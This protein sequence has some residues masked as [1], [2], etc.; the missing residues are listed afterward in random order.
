M[1]TFLIL[2]TLLSLTLTYTHSLTHTPITVSTLAGGGRLGNT[3]GSTQGIGVEARMSQ[4]YSLASDANFVYVPDYFNHRILRVD[5]I[6]GETSVL[7]GSHEASGDRDGY[8]HMARF[9]SPNAVDL[10]HHGNL[11]V[12][13]YGN[14]RIRKVEIATG[15][16][17]TIAGS[18]AGYTDGHGTVAKFNGPMGLALDKKG[19]VAY[20]TDPSN[21]LIRRL[22]LI[23]GMVSTIAGQYGQ[24]GA[25]DG[26]GNKA[27]F[28]YPFGISCDQSGK[29]LYV[30]DFSAH[31]I[32]T[33]DIT[34]SHVST[35]WGRHGKSGLTEGRGIHSLL[36]GPIDVAVDNAGNAYVADYNNN[37]IRKMVLSTGQTSTYVGHHQ[38]GSIDGDS[39]DA[40]FHGPHG[41]TINVDANDGFSQ[42]MY[43]AD[44]NNN[45]IRKVTMENEGSPRLAGF[46][47][48]QFQ[49]YG[50][51]NS[52]YN[53]IS[54]P[55]FQLNAGFSYIDNVVC[56]RNET[57]CSGPHAG[58]YLSVMGFRVGTHKVQVSLENGLL[59]VDLDDRRFAIRENVIT[60]DDKTS[61]MKLTKSNELIISSNTFRISITSDGSFLSMNAALLASDWLSQGAQQIHVYKDHN[62]PYPQVPCHGLLGQTWKNAVY[63]GGASIE[64]RTVDY[65]VHD[66]LFGTAYR[67]SYYITP[68]IDGI[69]DL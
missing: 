19:Q 10:D 20:I 54:S 32:R 55:T 3:A 5:A 6:S 7:A 33:I 22:D 26:I 57:D 61:T 38:S 69:N 1:N 64:G 12:V 39:N 53:L 9:N 23:T 2:V 8:A 36:N 14:H 17:T 37:K 35:L 45:K 43:V 27:R 30:A 31:T 49:V 21:R 25:D 65:L 63:P 67:F 29:L 24:I 28:W 13:D 34:T 59:V 62:N 48:Q 47:G 56:G 41:L 51:S 15:H 60:F 52:I 66:D 46:Q 18:V 44:A 58:Y 4:P 68:E 42:V 16:V 11:Y 40:L 50:I